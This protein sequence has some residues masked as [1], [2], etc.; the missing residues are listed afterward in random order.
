MTAGG[1]NKDVIYSSTVHVVQLYLI[2]SV[3]VSEPYSCME[4]QHSSTGGGM[5]ALTHVNGKAV[6]AALGALAMVYLLV[7]TALMTNKSNL[8]IPHGQ[9]FHSTFHLPITSSCWARGMTPDH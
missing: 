9:Q 6:T 5:G 2:N 3:V 1:P 7:M 8:H 4:I